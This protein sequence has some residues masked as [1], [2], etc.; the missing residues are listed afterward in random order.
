M[1]IFITIP[2]FVNENNKINA[3]IS[4]W[5]GFFPKDENIDNLLENITSSEFS[6]ISQ[7]H[8]SSV[9]FKVKY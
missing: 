8:P 7:I 2:Y 1:I 5:T 4:N 3:N 9:N 6:M